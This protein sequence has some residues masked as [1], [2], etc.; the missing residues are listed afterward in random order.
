MR[1]GHRFET[2]I[3]AAK[4]LENDPVAFIFVGGGEKWAWIEKEKVANNLENIHLL[5]YIPKEITPSALATADCTLITMNESALGVISPSKLHAYLAMSL[6]TLYVG[7]E[8]SNVDDAIK[9]F[10]AG[11]S[12]RHGD[13]A[14]VVGFISKLRTQPEELQT[15]RKHARRAFDEAFCDTQ[16]LPKFDRMLDQLIS[17]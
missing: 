4:R 10:N 7:P 3:D 8:G 1:F 15:L 11:A 17:N 6:P 14:G 9:R 2:I 5:R 16:T 12:F 13:T